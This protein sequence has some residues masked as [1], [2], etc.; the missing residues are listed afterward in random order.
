[1]G[2]C[3]SAQLSKAAFQKSGDL[4]CLSAIS[5]YEYDKNGVYHTRSSISS[6]SRPPISVLDEPKPRG[7]LLRRYHLGEELGRGEFGVTRRCTDAATGEALACKSI[8]KQRLRSSVDVEDVRREVQIMRGLPEH[9]NVVRLRDVFEDH[10]AVHLV[11]EICEGG[12][13]FDQ[14]VGR[15]HYTERAAATV[16]RTIMEVVQHCHLNGVIH[17]DL[18]PENFLFADSSETSPLKVID[19]G[20]SVDFKPGSGEIFGEIV[21]SPYYMAPE[22]LKRYYGQEVDIWSAGVI[23]YI[24]LC[25]VPPFWA[26]TDEGIAKAIIR[27]VI[28]FEREP[29][30]KISENAKDL[31][32]CMLDPNPHTR[33]T[34]Q[35]V[36]EHPWLQNTSTVPNIPLGEGVRSRLKQYS[37]MNKFKKKAMLVVTEHLPVEEIAAIKQMFHTMDTEQNG[38]LTLEALKKG[39]DLIGYR[40][41]DLDVQ[42]LMEAADID[43][44]G[45]VNCEEFVTVT[46]H[47]KRIDSEEHLPKAFNYFDKNQSGYIEIDELREAIGG[48]ELS[49][50]VILDIIAD[51]D[52][53]KDGRISYEEFEMM[54]KAGTDWRNGSR[55]YSRAMFNSL[56]HKMFKDGSLKE[57][58]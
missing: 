25:G 15:G 29:W 37:V 41:Q 5:I 13:L 39:L 48:L 14:I 22:I 6:E 50:Q 16:M 40:I 27:S 52:K 23:L 49:E 26:E 19:F 51:V 33:F 46:V 42:M 20:L 11:M 28:D 54:M 2:N 44:N 9:P 55:Q 38:T 35:K 3:C 17:R 30:P 43:G 58:T 34:A 10:E 1:M 36:L 53:D 24:L 7:D 32:R 12:E 4:R 31:V 47:L 8:A 21:G 45:T 56:S 57:H 18:K